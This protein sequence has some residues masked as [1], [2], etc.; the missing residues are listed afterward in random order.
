MSMVVTA[1]GLV[2]RP[3]VLGIVDLDVGSEVV[4]VLAEVTLVVVLLP[5]RPGWT[6]G[7]SWVSAGWPFACSDS[8]SRW[9]CCSASA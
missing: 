4:S 9:P 1:F 5:M 3:G 7:G 8:A 6:C 2:L